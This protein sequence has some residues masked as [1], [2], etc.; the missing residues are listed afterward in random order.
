MRRLRWPFPETAGS[1]L[2]TALLV[3]LI[4]PVGIAPADAQE[5]ASRRPPRP[6][7]TLPEGPVRQVI[8]RNCTACHGIDE[9][10]YYA[11]DRASWNALIDRM[12]T[13]TS[14]LIEGMEISDE[15]REILLD[16]LVAEF[17]PDAEPFERQYVVRPVTVETQLADLEAEALVDHACGSCHMPPDSV[18]RT[19]LDEDGWRST[20]TGKIAT[21][22]PLLIDEVDPLIDWI[23][24]TDE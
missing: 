9:Y 10:G 18:L 4:M 6:D 16:W 14:G 21:G 19:D 24:R 17:G 20:L 3:A 12:T 23:L 8:L 22:T 1:P 13:A 2:L 7:V 11:M 15:D 5:R